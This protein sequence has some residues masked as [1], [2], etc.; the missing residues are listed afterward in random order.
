MPDASIAD[1]SIAGASIAD[2]SIAGASIALQHVNKYRTERVS[3]VVI[4]NNL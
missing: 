3:W 2:A 1:A 4:I